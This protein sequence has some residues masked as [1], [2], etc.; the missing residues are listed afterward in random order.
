MQDRTINA[1]LLALRVQLIREDRN[2]LEHVEALLRLRRVPMPPVTRAP[3]KAFE[4][5]EL[6][7]ELAALLQDGPKPRAAIVAHVQ[8]AHGL[9]RR[10]ATECVK[11]T[12]GNMRRAGWVRSEGG[13][14]F[15]SLDNQHSES[16]NLVAQRVTISSRE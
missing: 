7:R 4:R 1:A 3:R 13:L 10:W 11:N 14:W 9:T 5:R 16:A 2:G 8:S 6:R 15:L 12:L